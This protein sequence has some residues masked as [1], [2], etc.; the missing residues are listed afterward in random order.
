[1]AT[2]FGTTATQAPQVQSFET[3]KKG[4]DKQPHFLKGVTDIFDQ[5]AKT[6]TARK[7]SEKNSVV[8]EFTR[9]QILIADALEQGVPGMTLSSAR[10]RSR[11]NF[12]AALESHP[13]LSE[14]LI[15]AQKAVVG[16]AG[17]GQVID[18]GTKQH[19]RQEA[20][21]DQLVSNGFLAI[22]DAT[23]PNKVRDADDLVRTAIAAQEVHA[24]RM[25]TL[26]LRSKQ[27]SIGSAEWTANERERKEVNRRFLIDTQ[28]AQFKQMEQQLQQITFGAGSEADKVQAINDLFTSHLSQASARLGDLSGDQS[29]ALLKPFEMLRDN[30]LERATGTLSDAEAKRS[31]ERVLEAGKQL[32]LQDPEVA[33]AV[34]AS[35]MFGDNALMQIM[36]RSDGLF[37]KVADMIAGKDVSHYSTNPQDKRATKAYTEEVTR[38][39][40]SSDPELRS[41]AEERVKRI[42]ESLVDDE[43]RIRRDPSAA[44]QPVKWIA[45]SEFLKASKNNPELFAGEMGDVRNV[46]TAHYADE[47]WGMVN[48]EFLKAEVVTP[49]EVEG[50]RAGSMGGVVEVRGD[51]TVTPLPDMVT[52]RT[53]SSG[54]E[55]YATD[56]SNRQSVARAQRLN[57]DLKPII[58][59]TVRAFAHMDGRN[60]YGAYWDE[61][62]ESFFQGQ[63][64]PAGGDEGDDISLEDFRFP[65]VSSGGL[66]PE[67]AQDSE[68]LSE[69]DRVAAKFEIEPS[70][71]LAVM[72]FET[73]GSFSPS[74]RNAAGSSATGLIQFMADTARG[75]GTSTSELSRMTRTEQMSFV[76][77]YLDQFDSKIRGGSA[78]DVYMAVLFPK[79]ANKP[80]SYVLFRQGTKAYQQ[81]RGLD[82][83]GDGTIT[84]AEAARKVVSLVGKHE[85]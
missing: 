14:D 67:V 41:E 37:T 40:D 20:R 8:A 5:A 62:S 27:L 79:A 51:S 68:F 26:D 25:R 60:D 34:A 29:R 17:L 50:F 15:K 21:I 44:F 46:L 83:N 63:A 80:D 36:I 19:Q 18:E 61:T 64:G 53:T 84:K 56:P 72:D 58:N 76:E 42:L 1:M 3:P 59:E 85:N 52:Y 75:L 69:V 81:N 57:K 22:E 47:V 16:T 11:K 6:I 28:P 77:K 49:G 33:N 9:Q 38:S 10:S 45:S 13:G 54:V 12:L 43:G 66:P 48:R 7:E 32:L 24:E 31:N 65:Q 71:L 4:V 30:Y 78:D 70:T 35:A 2:E 39:L 82:L 74:Q 55:F 23:N 73:G